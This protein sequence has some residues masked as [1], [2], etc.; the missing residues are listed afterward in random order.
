MPVEQGTA[1]LMASINYPTAQTLRIQSFDSAMDAAPSIAYPSP[2]LQSGFDLNLIYFLP[3]RVV[4]VKYARFIMIRYASRIV[5]SISHG[6]ANT[7]CVAR[8]PR[9]PF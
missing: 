3:L 8:L 4:P 1:I 7:L 5:C 2:S 6:N 9:A